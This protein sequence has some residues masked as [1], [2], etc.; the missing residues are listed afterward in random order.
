MIEGGGLGVFAP[1]EVGPIDVQVENGVVD[2]VV[3]DEA[4]AVAVA[5][6]YL[7][8]FQGPVEEWDVRGS[9]PPASGDPREPAAKSTTCAR[10][11]T[12]LADTGSVLELRRGF[13]TGWSP[14]SSAS[15]AGRSASIAN[16]PTASRRRDR[17]ARRGQGRALHAAVR[18]VRPA[19]PVP[20]RHAGHHGRPEVE[21]TALVRQ[22]RGCSSPA[23]TSPCRSSR[24]CCAR[25]TGSARRRWPAA[26][27]RRRVRGRR[28]RPASSAGWASKAPCGSDTARSS[29]RSTIPTSA[30]ATF[31]QMVAASYERGKAVNTASHFEIDDVIDPADSRRWITE[32]LRAMPPVPP[33]TGK[34]RPSIDTW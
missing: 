6:R 13:G 12:A 17:L 33:R 2:V 5:K 20:L 8:Y 23:R 24:S 14:R 30:S 9:A 16:N 7:S 32:A 3:E 22:R 31:Q 28:G 1:E 15:K 18:R 19:D 21:K 27:S 11:S 10:S 25:R 26:A 4:E 34:K 29:R